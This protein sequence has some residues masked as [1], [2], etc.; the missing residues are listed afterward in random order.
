MAGY[1]A[2]QETWAVIG[3]AERLD[4]VE[5]RQTIFHEGVHWVVSVYPRYLPLCL[6][7]GL[8]EVFSTFEIEKG[9]PR[10][11]KPICRH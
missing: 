1:F 9:K 6:N 5:T 4:D 10:W 7:E 11:G 3:M 2:R 8:A